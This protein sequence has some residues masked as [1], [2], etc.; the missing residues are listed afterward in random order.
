MCSSESLKHL[1]SERQIRIDETTIEE[2]EVDESDDTNT[3]API[4]NIIHDLR[5]P[6]V[7]RKHDDTD[8]DNR[9]KETRTETERVIMTRSR[10]KQMLDD[11]TIVNEEETETNQQEIMYLEEKNCSYWI[12]ATTTLDPGEPATLEALKGPERF[13]WMEAAGDEVMNF[14]KRGAWSKVSR[15]YV[16]DTLKRKPVKTTTVFKKKT[17]QDGS[18]QFKVRICSKGFM[19]IPGVDFDESFSPVG[20]DSGTRIVICITLYYRKVTRGMNEEDEWILE[21]YDVEAAFLSG[22]LR[23]KMYLEIPRE[24]IILG[25]ISEEEAKRNLIELMSNMYGNVDAARIYFEK[26]AKVMTMLG[27]TQSHT[28]PC[29]F[30]K[31][32][33][34]KKLHLILVTHVD[35]TLIAGPRKYVHEFMREFEQHMK[36]ERLGKLK[37]H[38]G[39]WYQWKK[40]KETNE[41]YLEA[42]M[43][44]LVS[45]VAIAFTH[46][47]GFEPKSYSTPGT[48]GTILKT[49]EEDPIMIKKYRSIV[50]KLLYFSTKLGPDVTNAV[51]ELSK[52]LSNPGQ[53]HW[54]ALERCVGYM[55]NNPHHMIFR[56]PRTLQSISYADSNFAKDPEDR[57]S[58]SG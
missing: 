11:A 46:A 42:N 24:L 25:F 1:F 35:D 6:E 27:L 20:T 50:G 43:A 47:M 40:D 55:Y 9:N 15:S 4:P 57:R 34:D 48:P 36:I 39:I 53:Q 41:E 31:H 45:K 21:G 38:L 19:M 12:F 10:A 44:K 58:I 51:R 16:V 14:L 13:Q 3:T 2:I 17:K 52:H 26:M 32:G 28:D 18:I 54:E 22:E 30:Y 8:H 37:K 49:N 29:V 5:P 56:M 33:K 7:G 23:K